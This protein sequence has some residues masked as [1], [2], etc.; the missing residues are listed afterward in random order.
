MY[1]LITALIALMIQSSISPWTSALPLSF[2]TFVTAFKQGYEDYLRYLADK[3][4]NHAMVTVIRNKC[5]QVGK[6]T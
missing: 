6:H 5:V 3:Q 1:F 4:V 2:V